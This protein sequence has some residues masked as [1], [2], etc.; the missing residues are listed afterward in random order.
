MSLCLLG[1][2]WG[3][4]Q[5]AL[6]WLQ[7]ISPQRSPHQQVPHVII[8]RLELPSCFRVILIP[9][10]R[11]MGMRGAELANEQEDPNAIFDHG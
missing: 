7:E 5:D 2:L 8:Q 9:W 10:L 4:A 11:D 3:Y 6:D 1:I